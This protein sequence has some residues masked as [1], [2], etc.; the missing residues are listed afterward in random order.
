MAFFTAIES[1]IWRWL[2]KYKV[3]VVGQLC[4]AKP[5]FK[6]SH[7]WLM[8]LGHKWLNQPPVGSRSLCPRSVYTWQC[9]FCTLLIISFRNAP[10]RRIPV[11]RSKNILNIGTFFY[12]AQI[13][14]QTWTYLVYPCAPCYQW[15]KGF[16]WSSGHFKWH[17]WQKESEF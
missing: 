17:R 14:V 11:L 7:H 13:K 9:I 16:Q 12:R 1:K 3:L 5:R 6:S 2:S 4:E 15:E 10:S 8:A